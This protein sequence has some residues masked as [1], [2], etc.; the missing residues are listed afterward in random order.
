V[1]GL[2]RGVANRVQAKGFKIGNV[3]NA[4]DQSRS[5]TIVEY[6]AGHRAEALAV[7]KLI[8]VGADAVEAMGAGT[9]VIAGQDAPVVVTVGAD[10]NPQQ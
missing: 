1:P 7:A 8:G 4:S 10:Q 3:T 2:A 6:D 9:R 5:A